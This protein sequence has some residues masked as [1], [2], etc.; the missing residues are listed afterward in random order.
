MNFI[1]SEKFQLFVCM[2]VA[3]CSLLSVC[4]YNDFLLKNCSN[5]KLIIFTDIT[6]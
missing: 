1:D 6:F 4:I 5:N 3:S 2:V